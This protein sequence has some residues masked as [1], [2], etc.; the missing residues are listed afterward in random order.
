MKLADTARIWQQAGVSVVP[1]LTNQ[2]KRPA[3]RWAEYQAEPPTLGQVEEWWGNGKSY[4]LALICGSVSG[5]LEMT[6]IEGRA[7]DGE[8]M[9]EIQ[10]CMDEVG[11]GDIWN[12]L[13]GPQG[14][15]EMSPS[16]GLHLLYRIVDHPV[17]G[18]T[19]IARNGDEIPLVLAETRGEGGYVIVAPTPGLCHPSGEAWVLLQGAYGHLPVITW[20]ARCRIHEAL[21]LALDYPTHLVIPAEPN[22]KSPQ[23]SSVSLTHQ[24]PAD[25]SWLPSSAL[26]INT[27]PAAL[28]EPP[29]SPRLSAAGLSPGDHFEASVDWSEILEQHGWRYA[30]RRGVERLWV[31]PGKD[32]REGHSATTGYAGDRDRMFVFSTSTTLPH[33]QALTKFAVYAHLN[34]HGDFHLAAQELRR[35]GFGDSPPP[36]DGFHIAQSDNDPS[37]PA[38][39][40]GNSRYLADRVRDRFLYLAEEKEYV[41]WDGTC[42]VRDQRFVLEHEFAEMCLE[43]ARIAL[44]QGDAATHKWWIKCTN[45]SRMEAAIKGLRSEPGFTVTVD[46][47]NKDRHLVNTENGIYNLKTH[48]FLPH[49]PRLLMTRKM[50]ARYNPEATCP[51]FENFMERVLPDEGMRSYVQ[52]ALGYSLLGEADQRSLFLVCGPSGTGKSTLMA[53]MELLFGGYGVSAPSGTLRARGTESSSPSND[54]HM[55]RGK[56]FVSTSETNEHTAYNE[57]LIKRLTGRDQIQSRELY[58]RFQSWSPQCTIWLATNHAPRFSSDDDAI[59]RR[60]KIV[61]FTTV[62]LG[63]GE[64]SDFAH[65]VLAYELDGIFN[66]LLAGLRAYQ[67]MGLLEPGSVQEAVHGVRLQADPVA[68]FLEDKLN[69]GLLIRDE[70]QQIRTAELYMMYAD[71]A[72]QMGERPVGNR[73]FTMRVRAAYPDLEVLRV[74]G[75]YSWK[76]LGKLTAIRGWVSKD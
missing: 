49:D 13:T 48:E 7:C 62:L 21:R 57:D 2:T 73:R 41:Q 53:T 1:I 46:E 10:N 45:R 63:D 47:M 20:E 33:E 29:S 8:S 64:V 39:D 11:V 15:S 12:L 25:R 9:T 16:G 30:G 22:D 58:Q 35:Q 61:P 74:G 3:V 69:D 32:P 18:N 27:A 56:R 50:G 67:E 43:R 6:E 4:G 19:K 54:L 40:L 60:A 66:W 34:H 75:H 51:E 52:R 28:P 36:L 59:W 70:V 5:N 42:W 14:Y 55:L 24:P 72:K 38:S 37:Y 71:W 17:P 26:A 31:R 65:N 76:G 44:E 68:R 23:L